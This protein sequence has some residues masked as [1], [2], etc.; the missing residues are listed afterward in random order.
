MNIYLSQT[1][2]PYVLRCY[3]CS[4]VRL[5]GFS[6]GLGENA[7]T[8]APGLILPF[9]ISSIF[10]IIYSHVNLTTRPWIIPTNHPQTPPRSYF[11]FKSEKCKLNFPICA[12]AELK[13]DRLITNVTLIP[14]LWLVEVK[15]CRRVS[16]SL[17][18][19]Q[20]KYALKRHRIFKLICTGYGAR[21]LF[22]RMAVIVKNTKF[23][24]QL[25]S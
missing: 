1:N 23:F 7:K 19:D 4:L 9:T 20:I 13:T 16:H 25:G 14:L 3:G 12:L 6:I 15:L 2:Y 8:R 5:K 18:R 24:I 17:V 10:L 22:R 11:N 21:V